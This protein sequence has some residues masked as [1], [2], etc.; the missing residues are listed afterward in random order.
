MNVKD[1]ILECERR[2]IDAQRTS[3]VKE[4]DQLLHEDLLF[5]IP[6]GQIIT[7][8]I[9]LDSHKSGDMSINSSIVLNQTI[10]L[11]EDV[12]VAV[13]TIELKGQYRN[14]PIDGKFVYN[15][16]WKQVSTQWKLISGSAVQ[17]S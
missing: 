17:A 9:D 13:T 3:N 11:I 14:Q 2:L 7:K 6:N 8:Q 15:R 16:V 1:A 12:A 10:K 5:T 4:L